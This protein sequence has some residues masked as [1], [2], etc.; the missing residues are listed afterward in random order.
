[1]SSPYRIGERKHSHRRMYIWLG[2]FL[3]ALVFGAVIG[4]RMLHADT[5][6]ADTPKV[7]TRKITY[8]TPNTGVFEGSTFKLTLPSDWKPMPVT[9]TPTPTYSWHGKSKDDV[10]RWIDVY[11]DADVAT[12]SLNRV[13]SVQANGAGLSVTSEVSDNCTNFTGAP[14][15][16]G[17]SHIQAKWQ[18]LT[19]LC[20][21]GNYAR[22]VVGTVS[23]DG[24]N[25]VI[26]T[27]PLKGMHHYLF[28]Y[29]DN[30]A[31]ADYKIFTD[32]LK[33]FV[34]K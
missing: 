27:G 14:V 31:S 7:V 22:D 18:N 10:A 21:T 13:V 29:T 20:E 23:P 16:S 15:G 2:G 9:D 6:I 1:M 33:S 24:L 3:A 17:Q 30:S 34:A 5:H 28:V 12:F 11:V 8:D 32:A 4:V 26:V 19:F 25:T